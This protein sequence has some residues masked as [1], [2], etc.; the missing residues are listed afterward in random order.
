MIKDRSLSYEEKLQRLGLTSLET[1]T[2]RGDLIKVV[3]ILKGFDNNKYTVFTARC[4]ASAVFAVIQC[5][6][7][8]LSVTFVDHVKTNKDIFAFF[9]PSG[10][11]TILIFPYQRG[12]RWS[13]GNPLTGASDARG[14]DKMT[15]SQISR[16]ISETVIVNGHM[17]RDNL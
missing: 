5:P 8:R 14:Y 1:R 3:K 16:C 6:S 4:D 11:N 9:L 13:D 7:V 17:Q 15:F 10:S 2:L 12:C